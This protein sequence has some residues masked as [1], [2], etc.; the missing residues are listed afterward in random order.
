MKR[1]VYFRLCDSF[2]FNMFHGDMVHGKTFLHSSFVCSSLSCSKGF[3][4]LFYGLEWCL[5]DM[6]WCLDD[7][8]WFGQNFDFL[9]KYG[10]WICP[11]PSLPVA[12]QTRPKKSKRIARN[13]TLKDVMEEGLC[14]A[15]EFHVIPYHFIP[16]H[17]IPY[18][19]HFLCK[20]ET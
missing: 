1:L 12:L 8:G 2:V 18:H 3:R 4:G 17:P 6:G 7:L 19:N 9:P 14:Y 15:T 20:A 16:Y 13:P 11:V 5:D 10:L